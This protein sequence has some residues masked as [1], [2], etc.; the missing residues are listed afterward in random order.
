MSEKVRPFGSL[1]QNFSSPFRCIGKTIA[2]PPQHFQSKLIIQEP[3]ALMHE[4]Y[5][6][7]LIANLLAA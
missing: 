5:E 2:N 4:L 7:D 6:H 3:I 1:R